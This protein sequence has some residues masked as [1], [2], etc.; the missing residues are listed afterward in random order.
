MRIWRCAV[1]AVL[2]A[3]NA[4]AK[5]V[6]PAKLLTPSGKWAIEY[7]KDMCALN[8][9]FGS[10]ADE[11]LL[12]IK[13]APNG[14]Q[15]RIMILRKGRSTDV[16][17]GKAGVRFSDGSVP[18][19]AVASSGWVKG[20][21]LTAVDMPRSALAPL[22]AG[23]RVSIR[24]GPG[25]NH[26]FAPTGMAA[27]MQALASCERD[28]LKSWGMS[29][30]EQDAIAEMPK[31]EYKGLFTANDYPS[32]MIDNGIQGSVG[33]LLSISATGAVTACRAIETSRAVELDEVTCAIL[34]RRAKFAPAI[35]KS[36]K[37]VPAVTYFR[38]VWMLDGGSGADY[39]NSASGPP[40]PP[41]S[42]AH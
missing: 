9:K 21:V 24:F 13:P 2:L 15:A 11:V 30:A 14:D 35:D 8:R 17:T 6:P 19:Y 33:A 31:V 42:A 39:S 16:R 34:R 18:T 28:L 23:G 20:M 10:G 32:K 27:A 38:V 41:M 7:A 12:A 3:G 37:A 1:I 26:E 40:S 25:L 36:G 22:I 29:E 5:P 4:L